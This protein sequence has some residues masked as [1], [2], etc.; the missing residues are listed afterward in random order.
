LANNELKNKFIFEELKDYFE[1]NNCEWDYYDNGSITLYCKFK[2]HIAQNGS[3]YFETLDEPY[4]NWHWK[5]INDF[6]NDIEGEG[7]GV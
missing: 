6:G 4:L 3:T 2:P 7:V 5:F 1:I